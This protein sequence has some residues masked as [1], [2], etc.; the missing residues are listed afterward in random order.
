[1]LQQTTVAAVTPRF[2]RFIARWPTIEA[3]AQASSDEILAEWAGL[4]YYARARNLIA[5]ARLV[6]TQGGFPGTEVELRKLP[7]IGDY[8]AAAIAAI[9]FGRDATPIDTN[10]ARVVARVHGLKQ[11]VAGNIRTLTQAM[12]PAGQAGD[13]AQAMMDLGATICRPRAPDCP[14]CPLKLD[15]VAFASGTPDAFPTP[16]PKRARPQ[17]FGIAYWVQ[18]QGAV[19]LVRRP[20]KGLLGGMAALPGPQWSGEPMPLVAPP[21]A[22][23]RH[24]FTHFALDLSVLSADRAEGDGWWHP[25]DRLDQAGLPTLYRHAAGQVLARAEECQG[26]R[27]D[28][29]A[30]VLED[31]PSPA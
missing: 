5:C 6:A 30:R 17:R 14:A 28:A 8:T 24:V 20:A 23:I 9:A 21:L 16:K 27:S 12:T 7:G 25:I 29:P 11:P 22:C 18:R 13:F 1:M 3:L 15:C 2:D 31:G 19:W 26:A 10:V 4:G